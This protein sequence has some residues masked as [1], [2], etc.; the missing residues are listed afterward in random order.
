MSST[1]SD[2]VE[3]APTSGAYDAFPYMAQA[4]AFTYVDHLAALAQLH[5]L[6]D[7]APADNCT[8][9]EL[10]C[11]AGANLIPMAETFPN[12]R[13]VGIDNSSRQLDDGRNLIQRLHLDNIQLL[14]TDIL[15]ISRDF[16]QFDYIIAHG[17]YSWVPVDVADK[18]LRICRENLSTTG[19]ALVSYN[20]YPGWRLRGVIRDLM[21][22][23]TR[24]LQDP[25]ARA[26]EARRLLSSLAQSVPANQTYGLLLQHEARQI[27]NAPDAL[28]IHDQLEDHNRPCY[29]HEFIEHAKSHDLRHLCDAEPRLIFA[30]EMSKELSAMLPPL[31]QFLEREQY[32][33]F[34]RGSSFRRSVLC[35][36]ERSPV[37]PA[38]HASLDGLYLTT[39]LRPS[40]KDPQ[41]FEGPGGLRVS[42][43]SPL[44]G[45]ILLEL[46]RCSPW[47]LA[48][49]DLI[50]RAERLIE[51]DKSLQGRTDIT[52]GRVGEFLLNLYLTRAIDVYSRHGDFVTAISQRP[53]ARPLARLTAAQGATAINRCHYSINL[54]PSARALVPLLDGTRG[55]DQLKSELSGQVGPDGLLLDPSSIEPDLQF[56]AFNALLIA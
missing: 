8:V 43:S 3:A 44:P 15:D 20:I 19:I 16:G 30:K 51:A 50:E 14:H 1:P 42:F 18:I 49:S 27:R 7:A 22:Y 5:G 12:S 23:H 34:I 45:K 56:L 48:Y 25:V 2:Q 55:R 38:T 52:P 13:F 32:T 17:V 4:F 33:D 31:S 40:Q 10:G 29:F 35:H 39:R 6:S 26:G 21:C 46:V 37:R 11:A 24:H 41:N 53:E 36:K 28:L 54:T 9:L 47:R